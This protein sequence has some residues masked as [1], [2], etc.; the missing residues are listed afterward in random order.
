MS[1]AGKPRRHALHSF[2]PSLRM[3]WQFLRMVPTARYSPGSRA[4][5]VPISGFMTPNCQTYDFQLPYFLN[6]I[7][8]AECSSVS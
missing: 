5:R 4:G 6:P 7:S 1:T 3:R 2:L 8:E